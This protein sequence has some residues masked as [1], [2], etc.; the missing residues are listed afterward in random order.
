MIGLATRAG[1]TVSGE[2]AVMSAVTAGHAKLVFVSEEASDSSKKT[3]AD[4]CSYYKTPVVICFGKEEL[5][6]ACGKD[7]RT[8]VAILDDGF[9]KA[10]KKLVDHNETEDFN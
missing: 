4:K 9:A 10:L 3:F 5:G 7:V 6:R 1:K 2:F 8:S